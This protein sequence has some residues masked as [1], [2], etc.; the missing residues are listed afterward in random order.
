MN[1]LDL[2]HRNGLLPINLGNARLITSYKDLIHIVQL[3]K[4]KE[5]ID[6]IHDSLAIFDNTTEYTGM[7]E[8]LKRK[9]DEVKTKLDAMMPHKRTKRG[10]IDGL[11]TIIK[12][13]TGNLDANDAIRINNEINKIFDNERQLET[14]LTQ[15]SQLN[16]QMIERFGNI[17]AHIN[18]QQKTITDYLKHINEISKNQIRNDNRN[19]KYSQ[20]MN[21]INI[22][23]DVL[24]NHLNGISEAIILAKFNIISKM[25]LNPQELTELYRLFEEQN[26]NITSDEHIYELLSLQ[27]YSNN[28]N[29][30]FNIRIPVLSKESYF[31]FHLIPLPI[32]KTR[33]I[34]TKPYAI[35]GHEHIQELDNKCQNIE[36]TFYCL[37]TTNL[38]KVSHSKCVAS[39][40]NHKPAECH[41]YDRENDIE[42]FEPEPNHLLLI[43]IPETMVNT[44][45]GPNDFK[46]KGTLLIHFKD[47]EI[48]INSI[49][50][51]SKI[52]TF[53]D[54]ISIHPAAFNNINFT[55]PTNNHLQLKRL[56]DY[57]FTNLRLEKDS[58]TDFELMDLHLP[59]SATTGII[60]VVFIIYYAFS[61]RTTKN[62]GLH[63]LPVIA[64]TNEPAKI[65]FLWPML[66][67]KGGGVTGSLP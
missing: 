18:Q 48:S 45:C 47:C 41:I 34:L 16:G 43:S 6:N 29:I 52:Q 20:Y 17:T 3:D 65:Q 54:E 30:I 9:V 23:I 38:E 56:G 67:T 49:T 31:L 25:I 46:A 39:I 5:N 66:H 22:N 62:S 64:P 24:D 26:I 37:E 59:L 10:L 60:L 53:W 58:I 32:N 33:T 19:I 40:L 14:K 55:S 13:I 4:Y 57:Q 61:R 7:V 28:S 42:I 2:T 1:L 44:T 63:T 21:Q 12:G 27:A 51:S 36:G 11:G 15:Q 50:Y 35:L 8:I